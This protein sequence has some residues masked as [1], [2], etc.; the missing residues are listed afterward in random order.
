M[1]VLSPPL[2]QTNGI[3]TDT[4]LEANRVYVANPTAP[5]VVTLPTDTASLNDGD[6]IILK[7]ITT[8][9]VQ[10]Q[11]ASARIEGVDQTVEITDNAP[12]RL[13]WTTAAF[14]TPFGWLLA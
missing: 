11:I 2:I 9:N 8:P 4:L 5:I 3:T 13:I 7:N 1:G 6:T 10:V 12:I 14:N